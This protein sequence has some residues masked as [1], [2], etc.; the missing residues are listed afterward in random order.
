MLK[1]I[2]LI[3][4]RI[5]GSEKQYNTREAK[6]IPEAVSIEK[7]KGTENPTTFVI[8]QEDGDIIEETAYEYSVKYKEKDE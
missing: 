6:I 8:T 4:F 5:G 2:R 3:L 7:K 1:I